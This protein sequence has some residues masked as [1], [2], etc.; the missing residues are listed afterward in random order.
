[1]GRGAVWPA[2]VLALTA[3]LA[4]CAQDEPG[5]ER[6]YDEGQVVRGEAL[7]QQYCAQCHG[8]AG[9]GAENW[10]QRD[11]SGRTGP[12]PL[13]GTGHTWHHGKDEL[14]HFIRHGLGPGM[15]PWRAVLSDDE[16][17][18]VIAY[19]QH[20]WPEEIYQAWQRYDARFREAGVDLGEE[21]VPQA[22]PQPPSSETPGGSPP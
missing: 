3:G 2:V 21:P 17:T 18:A 15:P 5:A 4:G 9:D 12:P 14:R 1:M 19:L 6:W 8:V 13:N 20:W 16:V 11:A 7:Y 22:H 10:R